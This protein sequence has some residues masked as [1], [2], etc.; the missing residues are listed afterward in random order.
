MAVRLG[1]LNLGVVAGLSLSDPKRLESID[2]PAAR[3]SSSQDLGELAASIELSGVLCGA[4]RFDDFRQLQR[5]KRLGNSL[6][7]DSEAVSTIVF[8]KDVKLAKV[9]VNILR[10]SISLKESLFKQ[11]NACDSL[12]DWASQTAGAVVS[13]V[14]VS[15]VP[16]E[17]LAC[18]KVSHEA[19]AAE[20][21]SLVYD[22]L[23]AVDLEDFDWLGFAWFMPDVSEISSAVVTV[24]DGLN[25]A[26]CDFSSQ[27]T[28]ADR[29]LR[30]R[31]HR[32]SF[33]NYD[34]V[35]WGRLDKIRFAVTK[36]EAQSYFFAVD[37]LGGF[38]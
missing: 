25:E 4:S 30:L 1:D 19:E 10:Y 23:D 7:F 11:V 37:D 33:V 22:P 21:F 15:P 31:I 8:I 18:I 13:A 38:E 17:G 6:K 2:L 24:S 26:A 36:A 16:F 27:L 14:S 32:T 9:G 5:Y 35:D 20:E 3:G 12:L 28:E 29:W 34:A